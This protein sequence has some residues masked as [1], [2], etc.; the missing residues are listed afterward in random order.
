MPLFHPR[1]LKRHTERIQA[2]AKH[3]ALLTQWA[4]NLERGVFDVETQSD[5]RFIQRILIDV[6]GFVGRG[7]APNWTLLKNQP[8]GNGNVDVALGNFTADAVQ[9][10]A[11]LELKGAKTKN[12]DAL[13]GAKR[14]PVQQAWDY[15]NDNEGTKWVLV[16]NYREI[17]LYAYG[18]GRKDYETFDLT[19][20][21]K[22]EQLYKQFI[23]LL[24]ADNL[25]G[26]KTLSLLAESEQANQD[27]TDKFYR[28]YKELRVRLIEIIGK[29]NTAIDKLDIIRYAQKILD[30][31][32][33]IAFAE[34]RDLL[35]KK[36]L[37][38][39]FTSV[40]HYNPQP[41]WKNFI[42][43]FH[44]IDEG[45]AA[46]G[47]TAYNGG[48]F[49][50]DPELNDLIVRDD[51]CKGFKEI[52]KYDFDTEI[53]VD[54][55]GHIFEQSISDLEELKAAAEGNAGTLDKKKSKRKADG[56]FYTPPYI[57]QYIVEQTVGGWLAERRKEIGFDTLLVLTDDDYD[58]VKQ[59]LKKTGKQSAKQSRNLQI[60]QHITAW[61]A[62]KEAVSH[63]KVLDPACG[64]GAFL[65]EVFDYL[66]REGK[67]INDELA[68]LQGGHSLF[69]WDTHILSNN[70]YGVD[71]NQESVEITK[72]SLWLKTARRNEKLTYLESNI[73]P[74]HSLIDDKTVV[75][76]LAFVWKEEFPDIMT[77]G[78]FDVIVG[79]PPY[80]ADI[81]QFV[82]VY[83]TLYPETSQGFKDIYKYF[84]QRATGLIKNGGMV[85]YITPN[86]FFRQPRYADLRSFLLKYKIEQLIDLGE[87]IFDV[88]VPT[89]ITIFSKNEKGEILFADLSK[90]EKRNDIKS[91]L[92]FT[93]IAQSIFE[94]TPNNIFV[95]SFRDK[96]NNEYLL[97]EILEM[98]DAG[99]KYQRINVG[100]NEKGNNDLAER[101]FYF[102]EKQNVDDIPTLIGKEINAYYHDLHPKQKLR[103]NYQSLLKANEKTYYNKAIMDEKVKLIWRQ[104]APYFIGTILREPLFFGNT[105]Q[106]GILK[107]QFVNRVSYEFLC[108]LLN[109]KYLRYLYECHVK[110]T[111][112]VF[113]QVK[114]EKLKSLPI[115]IADDQQPF[116]TLV[117]EMI[118]L[119]GK[120][121]QQREHFS[122]LLSDNLGVTISEKRFAELREFKDFL[123]ELK[124]QKKTLPLAEQPQWKESF[125]KC[126]GE[127]ESLIA[128]IRQT[129]AEIDR[130]VYEL[131]ELT[132][133][134][135]G[136]IGQAEPQK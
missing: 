27:I 55:L 33:F 24:S 92:R 20:L 47:I 113:P 36:I 35:P 70:L 79:N 68:R 129:D 30:R 19:A 80:G 31:I 57:T 97:D 23:L 125:V 71:L 61:E 3:I 123:D 32:L 101:I 91:Q 99:F 26:G 127:V 121:R 112:R 66:C 108:A 62:Y 86:T 90:S 81:D 107:E 128:T 75:G 89:S 8:I 134:E 10:I 60:A 13:Y 87:G 64:S 41:I 109:S 18:K 93:K 12:L 54:I 28:E 58:S 132:K 115:V 119:H 63:I 77:I 9:I 44:A 98:K 114:L 135:I 122:D 84:F 5:A 85:G 2:N 111:G 72:L 48:L 133:E 4:E 88:V 102:G 49:A 65:I 39:A 45:N 117:D 120:L 106:A 17:R 69:R 95:E 124:K 21:T 53:S 29:D 116:I 126:K 67:K 100:M 16:S 11:P 78:G 6:L 22:S 118:V 52:G 94:R 40:N 59:N 15:A 103:H 73:K 51:L 46:L 76:D 14:S 42:G 110:E 131:Y 136:I 7:D 130:L 83:E 34:S 82:D 104:T 50:D 25:L 74:G 105:I 43:L 96:R 56:I 38:D 37:Q 1:V